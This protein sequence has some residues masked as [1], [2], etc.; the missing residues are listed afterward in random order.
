MLAHATVDKMTAMHLPAMAEA[1]QRQLG[2]P[3][4]A[5]LSFDE[6]VGLL[7][8]S[9]WTAREQ[10]KL[11][12]RLR[13]A[14]LAARP[15]W[16]TSTGKSPA[17]PRPRAGPVARDLCLDRPASHAPPHRP[18][19]HREVLARRGIR[20]ARLPLRLLR[21]LRAGAAALPGAARRARRRLVLARA[22]P[23]GQD[24][25]GRDRRFGP[26]AAHEPPSA[27]TCW[28]CSRTAP[29]APPRSSP[30]RCRSRPGTS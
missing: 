27:T 23:P 2:S 5:D 21:L 18:H 28:K 16:K 24:R 8:D 15:R 30:A 7:I 10:R 22:R 25:P 6:R 9:E 29:S 19:R 12:R 13:T 26:G 17:R 3:Q 4:F 1:F 11:R 14:N 20:R